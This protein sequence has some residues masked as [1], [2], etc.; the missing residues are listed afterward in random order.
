MVL[1][2]K[3]DC[4]EL[5]PEW[6]TTVLAVAQAKTR[7]YVHHTIVESRFPRPLSPPASDVWIY[8]LLELP[9]LFRPTCN[10]G[11]VLKL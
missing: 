6:L 3:G 9:T 2:G 11:V 5:M 7:A 1:Y 4:D 8:L 10:D